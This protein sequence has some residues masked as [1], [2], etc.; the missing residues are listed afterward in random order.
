MAFVEQILRF[1]ICKRPLPSLLSLFHPSSPTFSFPLPPQLTPTTSLLQPRIMGFY[2]DSEKLYSHILNPAIMRRERREAK[3]RM[4]LLS[5]LACFIFLT[6][7]AFRQP[8]N[9]MSGHTHQP[10]NSTA[11]ATSRT[12]AESKS[13]IKG[14]HKSKGPFMGDVQRHLSDS[15]LA[16]LKNNSLGVRGLRILSHSSSY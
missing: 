16:D 5:L 9:F 8:N 6:M 14:S 11:L 10:A 7:V 2:D 15:S 4:V 12:D 13:W 3:R 1:L